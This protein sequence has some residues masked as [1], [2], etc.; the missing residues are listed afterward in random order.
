M[1]PQLEEIREKRDGRV[2][3]LLRYFSLIMAFFYMSAGVLFYFYP[4]L[5]NLGDTA[6]LLVCSGL[7]LYGIL[8]LIRLLKP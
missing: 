1:N 2:K 5:Q 3:N 7:F 4:V 6:K 8:R